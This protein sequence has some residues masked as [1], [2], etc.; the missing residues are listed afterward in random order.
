M[1]ATYPLISVIVPVY[2]VE[3]YI[4]R[5]IDS[6]IQQTYKN[7]EIILVDDGSPDNCGKI[8]DEYADLD[9]RIKVIHQQNGGLSAARNT[10][11]DICQ[12]EYIGFVDGDDCIHPE[13]YQRL[14][15]DICKYQVKLAFCHPNMC[16]HDEITPINEKESECKEKEYVIL[17]SLIENIWWSACT[18]LYKRKLFEKVRYPLNKVNEDY[19]ITITLYDQCDQI[20]VN[21]NKL[22]NYCIRENSIC[23]SPLNIKKFDQIGN[24][25]DVVHYM[26]DKHPE[27]KDAAE[28]VFFTT[29]IKLLSCTYNDKTQQFEQQKQEIINLMKTYCTSAQKNKYLNIQHKIMIWATKTNPILFKWINDFYNFKGKFQR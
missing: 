21:Y 7:L 23:T 1:K 6:I 13:M 29:L 2:K 14:Y 26:E 27:W 5:C 17:R 4:H 20:A 22:Y 15:D 28:F 10:G 12:G 16:Y 8:C 25:L 9:S 24:T 3:P 19:P 11:L 18:K